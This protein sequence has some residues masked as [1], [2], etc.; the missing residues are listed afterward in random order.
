LYE[1][2]EVTPEFAKKAKSQLIDYMSE[3]NIALISQDSN[4]ILETLNNISKKYFKS[5]RIF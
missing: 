5:S 4:L 2:Q 3:L 1:D